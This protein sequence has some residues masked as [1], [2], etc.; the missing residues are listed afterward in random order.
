MS[1][2]A[3]LYKHREHFDELPFSVVGGL[4]DEAVYIRIGSAQ[5]WK[6]AD[7]G[8]DM[9]DCM[10]V[11]ETIERMNRIEKENDESN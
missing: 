2:I 7:G 5:Y 11:I 6:C 10:E 9:T 3:K 1:S 8:W 4:P